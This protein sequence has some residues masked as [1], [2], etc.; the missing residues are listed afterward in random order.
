M[1]LPHLYN[2]DTNNFLIGNRYIYYCMKL[3]REFDDFEWIR[4][5]PGTIPFEDVRTGVAYNVILEQNFIDAI[6]A[7]DLMKGDGVDRMGLLN[8]TKVISKGIMVYMLYHHVF[9]GHERDDSV[10]ALYLLFLDENDDPIEHFWVTEDM[11]GLYPININLNESNDEWGW[12]KEPINPWVAGYTGIHFDID[13]T[14][15]TKEEIKKVREDVN[16]L[17]ESDGLD[18]IR[19]TQ[20][21]IP[22]SEAEID[23][24]YNITTTTVFL[25]ALEACSELYANEMYNSTQATVITRKHW[26]YSNVF[27]DS[28]DHTQVM[29]LLLEFDISDTHIQSFWVTEDMVL[30]NPIINKVNES[31]DG[32]DW[33]RDTELNLADGQNYLIDLTGAKPHEKLAIQRRLL[34]MGFRWRSG[35]VD[36]IHRYITEDYVAYSTWGERGTI[37]YLTKATTPDEFITGVGKK[38]NLHKIPY[39]YL[40]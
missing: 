21:S 22:F 15:S 10:L 30:L 28:D 31:E 27:C 35:D 16:Q 11:V 8:A 34:N 4:E 2:K 24:T 20:P 38:H 19:E 23:Q 3:I 13:L 18:W 32:L 29:S 26:A 33:I 9:C 37:G 14:N 6:K 12:A 17:T 25:K 36:I 7:C 5:V 40:L 39:Q 1:A